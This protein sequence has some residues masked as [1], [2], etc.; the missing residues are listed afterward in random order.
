MR[1][2]KRGHD[3]MPRLASR[4]DLRIVLPF[5]A[6]MLSSTK[7][8]SFN[9]SAWSNHYLVEWSSNRQNV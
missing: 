2:E 8:D 7:P 3:I 5:M 4:D 9:V 1:G 6:A